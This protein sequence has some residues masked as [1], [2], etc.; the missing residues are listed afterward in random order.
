MC[1]HAL[2]SICSAI[3]M[4][5]FC[6]GGLRLDSVNNISNWDFVKA[7]K[8]KAWELYNARYAAADPSRFLVIGEE[9]SLPIAM[10]QQ[11]CLDALWNENWLQRLRAVL[12]GEPWGGTGGISD[13][14]EWTVRKLVDCRQDELDGG[15]F[16][17]GAQAIIYITS[18]DIEGYHKN[19]LYNF[20]QDYRIWNV[21]Q[22]ARLAF[23]LLLT[24]VGVPM[25]FAGEEF[26]D[27]EDQSRDMLTGKQ[28]DPVNYARRDDPSDGAWRPTLFAYVARL[29]RFRTSCP[30][31]GVD[32]TDVFHVDDS[33]GGKIMAWQRG[34]GSSGTPSVVVVANFT[35]DD[36]PGTEYNVPNWPDR[37]VAGWR[38][39]SQDRDVPAE[40]VGKE[41]L[42]AW[43][44]KIYTHWRL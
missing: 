6:V 15:R 26:A 1:G 34:G 24:S 38:E 18:H 21:A 33:R 22:R 32:D 5:D 13:N 27:Q 36:T 23:A 17:D 41:P 14:F 31:L 25:I 20:C 44:A 7:Y 8:E 10:L 19:R 2:E 39:I 43:E 37:D 3:Q 29:V 28:N 42:Y 30:A 4:A 9:L 16:T 11:G 35:D 12:L 40:W